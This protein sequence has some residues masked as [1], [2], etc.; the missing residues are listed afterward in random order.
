[1]EVAMRVPEGWLRGR[2]EGW[3]F[4]SAYAPTAAVQY[5]TCA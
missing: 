1:M 5:R 4:A 3:S 2:G